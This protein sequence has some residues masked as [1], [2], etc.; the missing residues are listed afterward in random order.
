MPDTNRSIQKRSIPKTIMLDPELFA[1][2][3]RH[4]SQKKVNMTSGLWI[5]RLIR[6]EIYGGA[7]PG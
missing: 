7:R 5:Y 4:C 2:L 3:Q 6:A 1:R